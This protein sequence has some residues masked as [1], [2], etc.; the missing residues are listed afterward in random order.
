MGWSG[1]SKLFADV[2]ASIRRHCIGDS[3][4]KEE[5]YTDMIKAFENSDCDT[6]QEAVFR[7]DQDIVLW[8]AWMNRHSDFLEDWNGEKPNYEYGYHACALLSSLDDVPEV[9][10]AV[11]RPADNLTPVGDEGK[12]VATF[13]SVF[14]H[15]VERNRDKLNKAGFPG[16]G[17]YLKVEGCHEE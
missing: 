15:E 2:V 3:Y 8:R 7:S 16:G 12:I 5:V 4:Q 10:A 11:G 1:G 17:E 6:L 14:K 9:E 13:L